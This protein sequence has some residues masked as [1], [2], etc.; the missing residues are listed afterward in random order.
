[1]RPKFSPDG[2][3]IALTTPNSLR[4]TPRP[5]DEDRD[6]L[7]D[8]DPGNDL[9]GDGSMTQMRVTDSQA[10]FGITVLSEKG[11]SVRR[12]ILLGSREHGAERPR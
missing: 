1:M 11:G 8:E 5:Y 9:D 4:S 2:A 6:S 3:D 12:N 7:S 10:V